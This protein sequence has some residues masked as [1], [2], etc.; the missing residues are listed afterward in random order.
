MV[1]HIVKTPC[2]GICSTG[3]G[4]DVCRGCK[5]YGYEV[6]DW[7]GYSQSQKRIIDDRLDRFLSQIAQSKL[8][9]F[10]EGLLRWQ[11]DVQKVRVPPYRSLY[12]QAFVLLKTGGNQIRVPE[13]FGIRFLPVSQGLSVKELCKIID[14]EFYLLSDAHYQR[15]VK[16]GFKRGA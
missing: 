14:D 2:V 16:A 1:N 15:Y 11:I 10:D 12:C 5:R 7:N 8:E 6:I 13:Q 3:I 4:D 9:V